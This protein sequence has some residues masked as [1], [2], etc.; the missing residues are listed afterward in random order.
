MW[1]SCQRNQ[2]PHTT[3]LQ[4]SLYS[5]TRISRE[6]LPLLLYRLR[7]VYSSSRFFFDPSTCQSI[8]RRVPKWWCWIAAISGLWWSLM[9]T[10]FHSLPCFPGGAHP[11]PSS[12]LWSSFF[13]CVCVVFIQLSAQVPLLFWK[14]TQFQRRPYVRLRLCLYVWITRACLYL[15]HLRLH[16]WNTFF[17]RKREIERGR[18]KKRKTALTDWSLLC[19]QK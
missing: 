13:F 15:P 10:S 18:E 6:I 4:S 9:H 17:W 14:C 5:H 1:A 19:F 16:W 2:H 8:G 7:L 12:S 11:N 3:K